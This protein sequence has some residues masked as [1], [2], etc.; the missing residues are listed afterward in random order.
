MILASDGIAHDD[1]PQIVRCDAGVA[2][3]D[4]LCDRVVFAIAGAV[5]ER[6]ERRTPDVDRAVLGKIAHR[7]DRKIDRAI[8]LTEAGTSLKGFRIVHD[9][10]KSKGGRR[11]ATFAVSVA[12]RQLHPFVVELALDIKPFCPQA[13]RGQG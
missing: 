5:R 6:H 13:A 8:D 11:H 1:D 4:E 7:P 9:G 2:Q 10:E 3:G 12:K